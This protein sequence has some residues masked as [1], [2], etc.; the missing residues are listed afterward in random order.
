[1]KKNKKLIN[2]RSLLSAS[3]VTGG[4]ALLFSCKDKIENQIIE[5]KQNKKNIFNL[6]MVTT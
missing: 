3:L 4:S 1:M 6:K 2:R 5:D